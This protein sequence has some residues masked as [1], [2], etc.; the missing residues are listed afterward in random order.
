MHL[1]VPCTGVVI[2]AAGSGTRLGFG[3]PKAFA[4]LAGEPMLAHT[5]RALDALPGRVAVAIATPPADA[6]R[7]GI[8]HELLAALAAS[9]G[10]ERL[11]SAA[12]V[13]GGATRYDSVRAAIAQL[14]DVC[15]VILVHDAARALTPGELHERV[16]GAVRATGHGAV[17][18]L[19]VVDTIK[20]VDDDEVV[21]ETVDRSP[22]RAMQTPQGFPADAL[23]RAYERGSVAD[24]DDAATFAAAGG[25]VKIIP[26]HEDAFKITTPHDFARV[27][28][29]L[30]RRAGATVELRVGVGTDIHAFDDHSPCWLAGLHFPGEPG[31]SGHSDGDAA[32]HALVDALLGAA[33]LGDIGS[34]FGTDDPRF[35]NAHGEVFLRATRE[36]LEE[37][38][39]RIRNAT[40]QVICR[41]P[42][43]GRRSEEASELLSRVL[44]API[45]VSATTS[46]GLGFMAR[47]TDGGVFAI[48]TALLENENLR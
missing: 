45:S 21:L 31:L 28:R 14:P 17:P 22:L 7:G 35:A 37:A 33:G 29:E 23:R 40:V 39:W 20:R 19:P 32:S 46:D 38:G 18:G 26:G 48:A 11:I 3:V 25:T 34:T 9:M 2:V 41:R 4:E 27:E 42:R 43:F 1:G 36:L 44:G 16:A 15:D 5:V 6:E 13:E 24:T 47:T 12:V 30:A 10:S 8:A